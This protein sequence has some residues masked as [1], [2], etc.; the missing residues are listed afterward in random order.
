MLPEGGADRH[1]VEDG[2]D[3]NA[4]LGFHAGKR[5]TFPERDA[6]LV[7]GFLEF[8]VDFGRTVFVPHRCGVVD[9]V[10]EIY[11][12]KTAQVTPAGRGHALPFAEGVQT[13][14]QQ[15]LRFTLF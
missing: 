11:L 9:D 1:R 15:P 10:L 13:E 7:E 5:L 3:R 4:A 14:V 8:R 12:G 2:V 6:E